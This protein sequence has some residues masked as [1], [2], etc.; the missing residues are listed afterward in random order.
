MVAAT[1]TF[2]LSNLMSTCFPEFVTETQVLHALL[3]SSLKAD[4]QSRI[5]ITPEDGDITI[6]VR[7]AGGGRSGSEGGLGFYP[8]RWR[9]H[10]LGVRCRGRGAGGGSNSGGIGILPWRESR[11]WQSRFTEEICDSMDESRGSDE[12]EQGSDEVE[13]GCIDEAQASDEPEQEQSASR[14]LAP[15]QQPVDA[16]VEVV[17]ISDEDEELA[18]GRASW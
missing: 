14:D 7:S 17:E 4:G 10:N 6:W 2:K 5:T 12:Q 11:P 8:R 9:H 16:C 1:G 3:N 13:Q 18:A 15:G